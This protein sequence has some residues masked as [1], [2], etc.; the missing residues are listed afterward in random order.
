[1]RIHKH[2]LHGKGYI[3]GITIVNTEGEILFTAKFNLK[4]QENEE[5][6]E[7]VGRNFF[8][9]YDIDAEES[10]LFQCMK[11]GYPLSVDNQGIC[12]KDEGPHYISSLSVPI[13]RGKTVIGAIDLSVDEKVGDGANLI[14]I[15]LSTDEISSYSIGKAKP[16]VALLTLDDILAQSE[17]ML[18]LK[19]YAKTI[20]Q[21]DLPAIIYGETGTGK[22]IFAQ[23]IHNASPRSSGPFIAQNCAAIPETLLESMLFGT[24]A[25]SFTGAKNNPGLL[26]IARGGTIFLDEING[27]SLALQSKLLRVLQDGIYRPVGSNEAY[28]ADVKV[29]T[30][31]GEDPQVA[32]KEG[33]LRKDIYYRLSAMS[34]GLPPLR[35]RKED[36]YLFV[37]KY[38]RKYNEVFKKNIMYIGRDLQEKFIE[39]HWP[40]NIRELEHMIIFA[41][42]QVSENR[43]VLKY[44][45]VEEKFSALPV[46]DEM[47]RVSLKEALKEFEIEKIKEALNL[48]KN[49]ISEAARILSLP[50]QTLQN[51]I[52][53]YEIL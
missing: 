24:V 22:E 13:K 36:I 48:S 29:L 8:D 33:R 21:C 31:L 39:Y 52:G 5:N 11:V 35:E 1:M 41:M 40:G 7:V 42:T 17:R 14:P 4:L 10:S 19:E 34:L 9:V 47:E 45:D 18:E 3:D 12:Y 2:L 30:A 43:S 16:E 38:I 32:M 6:L 15:E 25:G 28:F 23:A 37:E 51:K 44:M 46:K 49:N 53:K 50:R 20:A 26:E 27:M